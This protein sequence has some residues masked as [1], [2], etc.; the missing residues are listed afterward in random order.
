MY[1]FLYSGSSPRT[2]RPRKGRFWNSSEANLGTK[3]GNASNTMKCG[4][5]R[6]KRKKEI[7]AKENETPRKEKQK[8]G[9]NPVVNKRIFR[10]NFEPNEASSLFRARSP[11]VKPGFA[12]WVQ[13]WAQG[14]VLFAKAFTHWGQPQ[15]HSV[16]TQRKARKSLLM[17][18]LC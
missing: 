2:Q 10:P 9:G 12:H 3:N 15:S 4:S 18:L 7:T 17:Y 11:R 1:L 14:S 13:R 5:T 16:L 8:K 6:K